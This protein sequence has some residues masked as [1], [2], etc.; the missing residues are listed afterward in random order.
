VSRLVTHCGIALRTAWRGI[1]R[2]AGTALATVLTIG[3]TLWVI[4]VFVLVGTNM[5]ALLEGLGEQIPVVAFFGEPVDEATALKWVRRAE[6]LEGVDAVVYVSQ[7]AALARFRNQVGGAALLEGVEGNPL[8]ASLEVSLGAEAREEASALRVAEALL[9]FEAIRDVQHGDDWLVGYIRALAVVDA[10]RWGL[11]AVLGLAALLIVSNTV[12]L[13]A[14]TRRDEIEILALVGASRSFVRGPFWIEGLLEGVAGGVLALFLLALAFAL[15]RVS[16]GGGFEML[17]GQVPP[18]F[19][20]PME[21]LGLVAV[22]ALLGLIG[23][24]LAVVSPRR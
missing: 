24:V 12:R 15:L 22:G 11:G 14:Y 19:L 2:S 4:G 6:A 18:R 7:E 20:D 1:G 9:D 23:A 13:G 17:L 8:P 3:L 10:I 5:R 16:A 21:S